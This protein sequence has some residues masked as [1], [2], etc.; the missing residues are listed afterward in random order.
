M[1]HRPQASIPDYHT[2]SQCMPLAV[3]I[4]SYVLM[5]RAL[6][7]R[8]ILPLALVMRPHAAELSAAVAAQP[9][10]GRIFPA[11]NSTGIILLEVRTWPADGQ[12][13]LPTPFPNIT[14]AHLLDGLKRGPLKWVFNDNATRLHLDVPT[15]TPATLP[16]TIA[17]ET[18][19]KT[20]QFTDGRIVFSALDAKVQ[21]NKAKLESH[22]GNHRIGFWT[23]PA[24][25]VNW[26]FKPM[27]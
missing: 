20:G 4:H 16:A 19:E 6:L 9:A 13:S 25:S 1:A 10:W 18:A 22:P 24:D 15:Q 27:R 12:L 8:L 23:D 3:S 14:A 7:W 26:D 21:G 5:R 17:L 2:G 11:T